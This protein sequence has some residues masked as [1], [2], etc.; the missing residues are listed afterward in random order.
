M[1]QINHGFTLIELMIVIA[2][3]GILAAIAIPQYQDYTIRTRVSE[4]A[5]LADGSK[6]AV[7]EFFNTNARW[8]SSN[9]SAG[10]F[11]STSIFGKYVSGVTVTGSGVITATVTAASGTSG[12]LVLTPT[13]N[14]GSIS[15]ACTGTIPPKYLP[16]ACR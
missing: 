1:K 6:W 16:S 4:A 15:W 14:R 10:V 12:T 3:I 9:A 13:D 11:S 7:G 2:I 8:P 5:V